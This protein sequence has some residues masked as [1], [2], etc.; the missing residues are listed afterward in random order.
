MGPEEGQGPSQQR[1]QQQPPP[2]ADWDRLAPWWRETFSNGADIEYELQI[3]PLA[4]GHLAGC[5]VV[6]DLGTG[7][8]QLARRLQR[9]G[10]RPA[11]VVGLDPSARQLFGATEQGGGPSYLRAVG[12]QMPF[13]DGSFDGVACCLV[14][15]HTEDA[16]T[17][18]A[19][20]ARVLAPGGRF[21]LLVN[22]PVVQGPGSGF[23]DDRV[24]DER[25]WRIGPYLTED[26]SVEEVDPGVE[27]RFS[28]R[29]LSRYINPLCDAGLALTRLEEPAPPVQFLSDSVDLSLELSMP[30]L[31]LMRFEKPARARPMEE[32]TADG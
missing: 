12:E 7:E 3:L 4:A 31:C 32:W 15:E 2:H 22:H 5:R 19:E 10:P 14:I 9:G 29:P 1:P 8:G 21:L 28:H 20:V 13:R 6:L 30:R 23:V 26:V 27:V 16:D 25:Y 24:L 11:L 18:L 17:V